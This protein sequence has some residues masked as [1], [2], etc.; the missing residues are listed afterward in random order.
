MFAVPLA[1]YDEAT[2]TDASEPKNRE[3]VLIGRERLRVT[4]SGRERRS[5]RDK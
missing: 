4:D 5:P 3:R 2:S 1:S